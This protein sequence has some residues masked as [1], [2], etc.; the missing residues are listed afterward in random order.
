MQTLDGFT[1]VSTWEKEKRA[2]GAKI[3][4][5]WFRAEIA[6]GRIQVLTVAGSAFVRRSD[7]EAAWTRYQAWRAERAKVRSESIHSA[8]A[9]NNERMLQTLAEIDRKLSLAL[10]ALGVQ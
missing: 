7:L 3:D 8:R 1:T 6:K 2:T 10:R 4:G 9:T 5:K